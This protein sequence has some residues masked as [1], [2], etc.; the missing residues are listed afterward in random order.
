[1][2]DDPYMWRHRWAEAIKQRD[3]AQLLNQELK[4]ELNHALVELHQARANV[5]AEPSRLEIA[6]MA[7][8]GLRTMSP[9]HAL[10]EADVLIAAAREGK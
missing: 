3:E 4:T 10:K 6:A 5:R 9:E 1:M 8:M 2:K 7:L